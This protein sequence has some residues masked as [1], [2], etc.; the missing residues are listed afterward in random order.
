MKARQERRPP[1]RHRLGPVSRLNC[2]RLHDARKK[3]RPIPLA[4][5]P[6]DI[7]NLI[8]KNPI[9]RL[10]RRR[11]GD[12]SIERCPERVDVRPWSVPCR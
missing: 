10:L 6:R 5:E 3:L 8:A 11:A 12:G 2:E 9:G 7:A 1:R 4:G